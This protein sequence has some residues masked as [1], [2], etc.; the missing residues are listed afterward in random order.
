MK[1]L[2]EPERLA[3]AKALLSVEEG[4]RLEVEGPLARH[5]CLGVLRRRGELDALMAKA[6]RPAWKLD[7]AVR[8]AIR[9]G[10]FELKQSRT[11]D[12]AAVDQAVQLT[13][14]LGS[15]RASGYVNAVLRKCSDLDWPADPLLN[16]PEWVV[17]RWKERLGLER[18]R[19]L[20]AA[21]DEPA[22][23]GLVGDTTGIQTRPSGVEGCVLADDAGSV[24]AL[25][26]Y[27]EGRW[28]VMD[29]A[30]V[31]VADLVPAEGRV[32]DACAAPGGKT[33]RLL[34]RGAEVVAVD[35]NENRLERLKVN[36]DRCKQQV[37]LRSVNW[38]KSD[39]E[40][41]GLFDSVLV[42][43]PCTGLGTTR[44][45]PEIRWSRLETDPLAM[46]LRQEAILEACASR[47]RPGGH[48]VYA[49]CSPTLEEGPTVARSLGWP[50]LQELD[51]LGKEDMDGHYAALLRKPA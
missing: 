46:S 24:M 29:P 26:G 14:K 51:T 19:A 33:L 23:L 11:P 10:L 34:Q 6:G 49:V 4:N 2:L 45:H 43:A 36:L 27:E 13:R 12:H 21:L 48:L 31:A 44:R 28:W 1:T 16:H 20:C 15:G 40:E 38:L 37:E 18:T 3:A 47:V 32:L 39:G 17:G 8:I 50:V 25:P 42:D 30:S 22:P 7:R 9:I 35:R 5:L 41:L